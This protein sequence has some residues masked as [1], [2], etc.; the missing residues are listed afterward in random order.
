MNYR[1]RK[2]HG[3]RPK[4]QGKYDH[5]HYP[6]NGTLIE[7]IDGFFENS[8]S[9]LEIWGFANE[10]GHEPHFHLI[11]EDERF[12]AVL[13]F[14]DAEYYD[15]VYE[16]SLLNDHQ[17]EILV[18]SL[19]N[20]WKSLVEKWNWDIYNYK[21][22]NYNPIPDY[23]KLGSQI[24]ENKKNKKRS[25]DWPTDRDIYYVHPGWVRTKKKR[26]WVHE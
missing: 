4:F 22:A 14:N 5:I 1:K 10:G 23:R 21:D 9:R 17:K 26:K 20:I 24:P 2:K 7:Y 8:E 16:Q 3:E 12:H 19:P 25:P 18:K 13:L 15:H 6:W 11:C